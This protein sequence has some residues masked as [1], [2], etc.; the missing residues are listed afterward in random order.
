MFIYTLTVMCLWKS[1]AGDCMAKIGCH[2]I[3]KKLVEFPWEPWGLI[4]GVCY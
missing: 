1:D 4:H 3:L 2:E